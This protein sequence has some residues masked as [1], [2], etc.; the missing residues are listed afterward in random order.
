MATSARR[1]ASTIWSLRSCRLAGWP[2]PPCSWRWRATST[3]DS[4][5]SG[6]AERYRAVTRDGSGARSDAEDRVVGGDAAELLV[7]RVRPHATEEDADLH[8]PALEVGAKERGL[9]VVGD[10]GRR[11]LLA[12]SADEKPPRAARAQVSHPLRVPP[13]RHEVP[14]PL[15]GQEVDGGPARLA[16]LP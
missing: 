3:F 6:T 13:G 10:L 12:P 2:C 15:D 11:E 1:I 16:R 4:P 5:S 9:L 7:G 8:P 14:T